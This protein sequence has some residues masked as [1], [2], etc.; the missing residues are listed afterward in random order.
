MNVCDTNLGL[1][2]NIAS[3]F[4][5]GNRPLYSIYDTCDCPPGYVFDNTRCGMFV[6]LQSSL[7]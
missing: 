3:N 4:S 2:C 5:Y 1:Y 6:N 7:F